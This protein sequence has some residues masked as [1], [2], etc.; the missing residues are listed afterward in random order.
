MKKNL[1]QIALFSFILVCLIYGVQWAVESAFRHRV[2]HKFTRI[3]NSEVNPEIMIFGS[4]VAY[5]QFDP[6][7]IKVNSTDK[8]YNMGWDGVFFVQYSALIKQYL[9]YQTNC[10]VLVMA[11]DFDN[12]GKNE[13]I[14]RPDLMLAYLN[15][16]FVY[17]SLHEIE[18]GNMLKARYVP[19]YKLTLLNKAFYKDIAF[20]GKNEDKLSGYDPIDIPWDVTD[21]VKPFTARYNDTIFNELRAVVDEVA[22]KG[23]KVVIVMTPVYEEGYKLITN[24]E[25]IK[26]KYRSLV[27]KNV[28]YFDY[29]VD[30][31]CRSKEYFH[32]YSHLNKTGA[33]LFSNNFASR[34]KTL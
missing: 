9:T 20:A 14:T 12:L 23:I 8:A 4:S 5:H 16:P 33:T 21:S 32:N 3:F 11:C 15:N 6:E 2:K 7:L 24:A 26:D 10:K 31:I 25:E 28:Y 18:P 13:L 17:H 22:A 34:L 1:Q 30:S 27:K 29:T 19:G